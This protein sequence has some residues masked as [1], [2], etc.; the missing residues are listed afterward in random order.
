MGI[1]A[2]NSTTFSENI[3]HRLENLVYIYL[4]SKYKELFYFKDKGECDFVAMERGNVRQLVQVCH[5]VD[6][7]NFEREYGGLLSAMKFFN[8]KS[9]VIV[10]FNQQDTFEK[11]GYTVRLVPAYKFLSE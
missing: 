7:M 6:D 8:L 10:T 3:G 5:L 11:D 2:Q 1:Y 9:G 4:R